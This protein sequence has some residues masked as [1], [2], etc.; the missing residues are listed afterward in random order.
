MKWVFWAWIALFCISIGTAGLAIVS[1]RPRAG[2]ETQPLQ[3]LITATNTAKALPDGTLVVSLADGAEVTAPYVLRESTLAVGGMSLIL[4]KGARSHSLTGRANLVVKATAGEYQLWARTLW[5]DSCSNSAAVE[6]GKAPEMVIGN[7]SVYGSWHW[8]PVGKCS[9][10]EGDNKVVIKEREDGTEIDQLLF[11]RD[12]AYMPT[13]PIS[14]AGELRGIRQFG[15]DFTR[16]PGHGMEA[17]DLISGKWDISFSFDPNRIPNQYA[18]LGKPENGTAQAFVKGPAWYGCRVVFSVFPQEA[19][20]F[21]VIV[22]RKSDGSDARATLDVATAG[23]RAECGTK[24]EHQADMGKRL[25]IGQWHRVEVE[26]WAW[27]LRV[28][29]DGKDVC[30]RHDLPPVAGAAGLFVESGQ[31]YFDDLR[32]EEIPWFADDGNKQEAPWTLAPDAKWFRGGAEEGQPAMLV[33]QSGA[34]SLGGGTLAPAEVLLEEDPETAG[35]CVINAAGLKEIEAKAPKE[36]RAKDSKEGDA[37]EAKPVLRIFRAEQLTAGGTVDVTTTPQQETRLR[38]VAI[39]F[40]LPTP[41]RYVI[42]PYHFTEPE[43]EDPSDYLDFTPEEYKKM[44]Q[45][46]DA[47]KLRRQA[48]F[49]P[50][51]GDRRDDESPWVRESG[52]WRIYEGMLSGMGTNATLRYAQEL[53]GPYELKLRFRIPDGKGAFEIDAAAGPDPALRVR[54]GGVKPEKI[55]PPVAGLLFVDAPKDSQWHTLTV[56]TRAEGLTAQVD[57]TPEQALNVKHGDG[58][59]LYLRVAQGRVDFDDIEF[60]MDHARDD[61]CIA[62]FNHR[63]TDWWREGEPN[64]W[65]DHG[66]IAC[67]LASSW[68]SLISPDGAGMLWHKDLFGPDAQVA[69]DVEE[70]TTWY[71]WDKYPSHVHYPY[72]NICVGLNAG[73]DDGYRLEVNAER[74]RATI[75]YRNN[76]EVARIRQDGYFPMHYI[77][78]H[79]PYMPRRNRII[80]SKRGGDVRVI[81]NGREMLKYKDPAPL[82]VRRAGLGGYNTHINFSNIEVLRLK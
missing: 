78:S 23:A 80:L 77:G 64:A 5:R 71:G 75:L 19:A 34:M 56:R 11:T 74:R 32:I 43:I 51:V 41:D 53:A 12:V 72:D 70:N 36:T 18:L 25:R 15:D 17:W 82:E 24:S 39:R 38:R 58:G 48:K 1:V 26:R 42:G 14:P 69:F 46:P 9:L 22:D 44:E 49:K 33:G 8:V 3:A 52:S 73:G 45:S 21:G 76:V 35:R 54:L 20:K 55:M 6:V 60:Q 10:A 2:G 59:R 30:V 13:G 67:V 68:I 62:V 16:S 28:R 31:V 4:P 40:A 79:M 81:I 7:D 57:K 47:D 61:G 37:A 29:I 63:E 50:L 27:T 65:V 66:G